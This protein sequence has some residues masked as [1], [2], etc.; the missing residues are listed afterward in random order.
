MRYTVD[1]DQ[2]LSFLSNF[3]DSAFIKQWPQLSSQQKKHLAAQIERIDLPMLHLQQQLLMQEGGDQH[4]DIAPFSAYARCGNREDQE[5]GKEAIAQGLVGCLVVAGGQGTRL[6]LDGPKGICEVSAIRKKSLFQLLAEKTLAAG[7]QVNRLLPLAIMTSPL[8]HDDTVSFFERH[9]RFGLASSQLAFFSQRMLPL[10]NSQ[11]R[12]FLENIDTLAVGPD[13]NGGALQQFVRCGLWKQW[14]AAGVRYVN[15][16]LID[17]AL[18]DPFD[19]ELIG[20][21][22]RRQCDVVIK[23]TFRHT[24]EEKVGVI[25]QEKGKPAVVEY[26][27]LSQKERTD[28]RSDGTLRHLLA[29]LSL[30]A[31]DMSF[32][33]QAAET[34]LPLH[35]AFKA[36]KYLNEKGV[37][38]QAVHPMAWKFERFIFDVLPLGSRVEA[39]V[40]PRDMCFAPLKNF[41][42]EGSVDTVS[43]A[44]QQR[45]RQIIETMTGHPCK[46]DPIEISQDFYYPTKE[47]L[48]AWKGKHV[49]RSGYLDSGKCGK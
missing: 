24:P 32:I 4:A 7:K 44:L 19:A 22:Q 49:T 1:E 46:V 3:G 31:F 47:L 25:V 2:L 13:G 10:L 23:C 42:G 14:Q 28:T 8:N 35:K 39:L 18:A 37:T 12:L 48:K 20:Y 36:V 9:E 34:S 11:G 5:R 21:Q 43:Q 30:F 38:I 26:T 6:R 40:Y 45:D 27:E 16:I 33:Q 29:N 41:H 17:N 15:F